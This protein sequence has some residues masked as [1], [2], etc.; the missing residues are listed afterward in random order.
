MCQKLKIN[1]N[2]FIDQTVKYKIE[3]SRNLNTIFSDMEQLQSNKNMYERIFNKLKIMGVHESIKSLDGELED[4]EA[5]LKSIQDA[6]KC[7]S[8]IFLEE[9]K[10]FSQYDD[11]EYYDYDYDDEDK[12]S[13]A[14]ELIENLKN[15]EKNIEESIKR[16]RKEITIAREEKEIMDFLKSMITEIRE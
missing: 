2:F 8:H 16:I 5:D 6:I 14:N 13:V 3:I 9:A 10:Y 4:F 11:I 15:K 7:T 1:F 12:I